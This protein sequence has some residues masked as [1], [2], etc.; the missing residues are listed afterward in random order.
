MGRVNRDYIVELIH[1][2]RQPTSASMNVQGHEDV[3]GWK[4][5]F[6]IVFDEKLGAGKYMP[7]LIKLL[8]P[9]H[10]FRTAYFDRYHEKYSKHRCSQAKVLGFY[11]YYTGKEIKNLYGAYSFYASTVFDTEPLSNGVTSCRFRDVHLEYF[12]DRDVLP[13]R[14]DSGYQICAGGIH[15][16]YEKRSALL[17]L[18]QEILGW[19]MKPRYNSKLLFSLHRSHLRNQK[20]KKS[21]K[22][23]P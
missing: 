5:G 2:Y 14:Y 9:K 23:K 15:Y 4:G 10:A 22:N 13:N 12:K 1:G 7:V 3:I 6:Y 11:S 19:H 21:S 17:Y 20:A 18:D 8:I 16:F